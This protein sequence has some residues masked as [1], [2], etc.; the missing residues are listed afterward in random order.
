MAQSVVMYSTEGGKYPVEEYITKLA[1]KHK[2]A[3]LAAIRLYVK[4]LGK[5][6][7]E[8]NKYH[9]NTIKLL[10]DGIY[11][12]RPN[13]TRIFFFC[14]AKNTMVL[15]HAF[16]KKRWSIPPREIELAI[17]EKNDFLRRSDNGK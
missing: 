1:K 4:R 11:E 8:V 10:R 12:L 2:E 5:Y 13:A 9:S 15:L 16:E 14:F 17:K 3:E 6:G 7:L